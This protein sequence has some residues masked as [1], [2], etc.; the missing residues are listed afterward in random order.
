MKTLEDVTKVRHCV[1]LAFEAAEREFVCCNK[2]E[3]INI[4]VIGAGPTGLELAGTP[5]E[6]ARKPLAE[7]GSRKSA[8][9]AGHYRPTVR[10]FDRP[11]VNHS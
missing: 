8:G 6:I 9:R 10:S 11:M 5:A 1:L 2:H 3:Q 7:W 4:V